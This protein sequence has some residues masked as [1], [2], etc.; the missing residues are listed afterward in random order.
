MDNT[1]SGLD[2]HMHYL[3]QVTLPSVA[4]DLVSILLDLLPRSPRRPLSP[5]PPVAMV[6]DG[7]WEGGS[8]PC[9][10]RFFLA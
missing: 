4:T 9:S 1:I 10:F 3:K 2:K 7:E 6:A 5:P 8:V